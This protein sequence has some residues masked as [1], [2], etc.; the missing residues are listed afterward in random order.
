ML[1]PEDSANY[2]CL[3]SSVLSQDGYARRQFAYLH[4]NEVTPA[5]ERLLVSTDV[6]RLERDCHKNPEILAFSV[7]AGSEIRR[8]T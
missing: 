8:R 7:G 6:K 4:T 1:L 5:E 2:P 3:G